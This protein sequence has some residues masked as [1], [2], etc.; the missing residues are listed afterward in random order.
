MKASQCTLYTGGH[1]GAETFFG[2]CAE[3]WGVN[4]V[5]FSFEGHYIKRARNVVML[6]P[7]DLIR[8]DISMEIVSLHMKR[9]YAQADKIKNVLQSIY[10]MVNKGMQVFAVGNIHDDGTVVGGTGW[11]V[12]LGKFF[13]RNVHVFDKSTNAW[14]SWRH[15]EWVKDSP[16]I[17]ETTIC[18]TGTRE[19]TEQ[20]CA[21]IE[22]LFTRS[23]GAV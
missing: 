14:H 18:G 10:H 9:Q 20:A 22:E 4:E 1:V 8:G 19:M 6:S 12:E 2:E 5:T 17:M 21:G 16:V 11:G 15:G 3:R 13:N 23:F 7:A